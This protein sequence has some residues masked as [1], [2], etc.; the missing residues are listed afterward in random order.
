MKLHVGN[1]V[2]GKN[3]IPSA[4]DFDMIDKFM[5]VTDE[6]SAH[7][8]R[9]TRDLF[10]YTEPFLQTIKQYADEGEFDVNS[11]VIVILR[12]VLVIW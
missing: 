12:S 2:S 5:K 1:E 6:R 9:P 4:T 8:A 7:S 11:N 10:G 3:L